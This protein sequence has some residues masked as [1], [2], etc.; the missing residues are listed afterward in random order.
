MHPNHRAKCSTSTATLQSKLPAT[1][2][3][4]ID[5][6]F[7][8]FMAHTQQLPANTDHVQEVD[9]YVSQDN[10]EVLSLRSCLRLVNAFLHYNAALP[11]SAA[12]KF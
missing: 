3:T 6:N 9:K 11:S 1:S 2:T 12:Y 8:S 7:F 4:I 5:D 10:T